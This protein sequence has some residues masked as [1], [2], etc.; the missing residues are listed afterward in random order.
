V[1]RDS[2]IVLRYGSRAAL[3]AV[4]AANGLLKGEPFLIDDEG[5]FGV[6]LSVSTYESF[7]KASEA[8][9]GS[10]SGTATITLPYQSGA[11]EWTET[12]AAPGVLATNTILALLAPG[13]DADE[14]N[15]DLI[16][17]ITLVARPELDS[18]TFTLTVSSPAS[19]PI[20]IN[21]KVL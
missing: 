9:G 3:D 7:A 20:L 19:G 17:L 18:I 10:L 21:W 14:N 16:D 15:A 13:S 8:G 1:P 4:A 5:R 12:V 6:A 11:L 2:P